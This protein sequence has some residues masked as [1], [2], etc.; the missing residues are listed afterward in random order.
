LRGLHGKNFKDAVQEQI[1]A[2]VRI[3]LKMLQTQCE[4][5]LLVE[6]ESEFEVV[7]GK[8]RLEKLKYRIWRLQP[9]LNQTEKVL[10]DH[11]SVPL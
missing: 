10:W 7:V 11:Y 5:L 1:F 6:A 4:E 3:N 8:E 9:V 2:I